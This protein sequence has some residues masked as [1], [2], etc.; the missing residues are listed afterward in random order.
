MATEE[1]DT[2]VWDSTRRWVESQLESGERI[3]DVAWFDG[4]LTAHVRRISVTG[5][6]S[7]RDLVLRS[8]TSDGFR[9]RAADLLTQEARLLR[10]LDDAD[11]VPAPHLVA[12]DPAAAHTD[13]PSLLMTAL[14]GEPCLD[15]V[16]AEWRSADLAAQLVA[17]HRLDVGT[18]DRPRPFRAWIDPEDFALPDTRRPLWAAARDVIRGPRPEVVGIFMHRDFHPGNVL[19]HDGRITGVVDWVETS[20]GPADLDVAHCATN[21]AMLYGADAGLAFAHHYQ[22]AGGQLAATPQDRQYWRLIDALAF[23]GETLRWVTFAWNRLGRTDLTLDV[24][25]ARLE[26]YVA[27]VLDTAE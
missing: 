14:P 11:G 22:S 8:F 17:I 10:L 21:L 5:P 7:D 4:G 16:G 26:D 27:A 25:T 23:A 18:A 19:F 9:Q 12:V 15:P 13:D 6:H 20:W 2:Q 24:M 1:R 3:T